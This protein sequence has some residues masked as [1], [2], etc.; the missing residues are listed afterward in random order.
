MPEYSDI[1]SRDEISVLSEYLG[2]ERLPLMSAPMDYVTGERMASAMYNEGAY[3]VV[4]RFGDTN[5]YE[6]D[7]YERALSI[8]VK[9]LDISLEWLVKHPS[10]AICIDVAH[11]HHKLVLD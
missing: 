4:S 6:N 7:D 11:G 5:D 8:G 2:A 10:H 9:D 3:G 1:E